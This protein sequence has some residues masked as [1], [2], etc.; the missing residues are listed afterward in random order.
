MRAEAVEE[1]RFEW[2]RFGILA[3]KFTG[4]K[5]PEV[6]PLLREILKP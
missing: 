3:G 4:V 1:Y 2:L 5:K 6:P